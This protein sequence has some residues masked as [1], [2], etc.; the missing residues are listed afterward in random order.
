MIWHQTKIKYN[1]KIVQNIFKLATSA[2]LPH[3]MTIVEKVFLLVI[4][5]MFCNCDVSSD[6]EKSFTE[7]E[8]IPDTLKTAPK[9]LLS[10]SIGNKQ[11]KKYKK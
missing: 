7:N 9:K 6:I 4:M 11:K 2:K 1:I 10:V 8:I 5:T 3:M